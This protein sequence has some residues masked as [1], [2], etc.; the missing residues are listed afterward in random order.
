[1]AS[2]RSLADDLD[3]ERSTVSRELAGL[4]R[5]GLITTSSGTDKR[6]TILALTP[7]GHKTLSAAFDAWQRA[8]AAI[9]DEYG[10]DKLDAFLS[11]MRQFARTVKSLAQ[12][13][14]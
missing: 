4:K 5:L 6:A 14:K 11:E 9:A 8:H 13:D 10:Q 2:I 12:R 3:L 1:T 7:R